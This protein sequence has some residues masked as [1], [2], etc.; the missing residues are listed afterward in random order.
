MTRQGGAEL[1][2]R[3]GTELF[4]ALDGEDPA[5]PAPA[6]AETRRDAP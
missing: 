1:A 3:A 4:L 5:H 2:L 6:C